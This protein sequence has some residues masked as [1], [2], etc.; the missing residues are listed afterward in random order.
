MSIFQPS[1]EFYLDVARG[2][3]ATSSALMVIGR[4]QNQNISVQDVWGAGQTWAQSPNPRQ[5]NIKSTSANDTAF[6]T[7]ARTVLI[8]GLD[9]NYAL[10]TETVTLNGTSNVITANLWYTINSI[11]VSTFGSLGYNDGVITAT[12][13]TALTVSNQIDA[14][15]NV[16]QSSVYQV[17]LTYSAYILDYNLSVNNPC[18]IDLMVKPFG[19]SF[20]NIQHTV[21]LSGQSNREM[22]FVMPIKVEA[23][24][25]I[26]ARCS[27]NS[28]N[29]DVSCAYSMVL[30]KDNLARANTLT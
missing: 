27:T 5:H 28:N 30:L 14:N 10:Q 3:V 4:N 16:S 23:K 21:M 22:A 29:T 1:K 15:M 12:D 8:S 7:G 6:G 11:T 25:I 20:Y 19:Q 9:E 24:S 17:P 2:L 13:D 18:S 26:K